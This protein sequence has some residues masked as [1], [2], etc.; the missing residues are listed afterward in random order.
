MNEVRITL[1][2]RKTIL[3]VRESILVQSG[4]PIS[5]C[6]I[7]TITKRH[8]E[9]GHPV[10]GAAPRVMSVFEFVTLKEGTA[11]ISV[12]PNRSARA[13]ERYSIG[14][15]SIS[16]LK[17]G[18][19]QSSTL[20]RDNVL[21]V[22]VAGPLTLLDS[23][24]GLQSCSGFMALIR[25]ARHQ[26]WKSI[27]SSSI[28]TI[29]SSSRKPFGKCLQKVE[30]STSRNGSCGLMERFVAYVALAARRLMLA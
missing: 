1:V 18:N 16:T 7:L 26:R 14:S 23:T 22:R 20:P 11:G 8:V 27:W 21:R 28:L 30:V 4:T 6:Y 19:K 15:A 3:S 2:S 17:I 29:A 12:G 24:T 13:M 9:S 5:H 10:Y 25:A